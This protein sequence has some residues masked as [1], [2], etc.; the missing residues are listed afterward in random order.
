M[1]VVIISSTAIQN[2]TANITIYLALKKVK[3]NIVKLFPNSTFNWRIVWLTLSV[4]LRVILE[5]L[6]SE[7][8]PKEI[9]V[10]N[11]IADLI[12]GIGTLI[13]VCVVGMMT[14]YII[15]E[16][17]NCEQPKEINK[18]TVNF[19]SLVDELGPHLL[20]VLTVTVLRITIVIYGAIKF[21]TGCQG[22]Q[23]YLLSLSYFTIISVD[24]Q[25]IMFYCCSLHRC[26]AAFKNM[27]DKLR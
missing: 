4:I 14:N 11:T 15:T 22:L 26:N 12:C 16:T 3:F 21:I 24:V 8:T 7:N 20:S 23:S 2:L 6:I 5:C 9:Q 17:L 10:L 18:L 19:S 25:V 1:V 13:C 27:S